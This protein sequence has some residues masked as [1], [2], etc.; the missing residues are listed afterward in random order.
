M[1]QFGD[2]EEEMN[3]L[4]CEKCQ[5]IHPENYDDLTC[6]NPECGG[7]L[8]LVDIDFGYTERNGNPRNPSILAS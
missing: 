4:I 5:L 8:I 3:V 7:K 2:K 6:R 1:S